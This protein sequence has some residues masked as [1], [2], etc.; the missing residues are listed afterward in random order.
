[1]Y[2]PSHWLES[3]SSPRQGS[4]P[5]FFSSKSYWSLEFLRHR[6]QVWSSSQCIFSVYVYVCVRESSM[7]AVWWGVC[8]III[9][10]HDLFRNSKNFPVSWMLLFITPKFSVQNPTGQQK[11]HF[12]LAV[13]V[14]IC[15]CACMHVCVSV[16]VSSGIMNRLTVGETTPPRAS[17]KALHS[18]AASCE[19]EHRLQVKTRSQE[20]PL[21]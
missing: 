20:P 15:A 14:F 8:D 12:N 7:N 1:M 2:L 11:Q 17:R 13:F 10:I 16:C 19:S 6:E 18:L 21:F 4:S 9:V 3:L 5:L